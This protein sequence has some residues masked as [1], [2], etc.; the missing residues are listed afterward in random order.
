MEM[1]KAKDMAKIKEA[2]HTFNKEK[3]QNPEKGK[4]KSIINRSPKRKTA[5]RAGTEEETENIVTIDTA[6]HPT[7]HEHLKKS[8]ETNFRTIEQ[9][10]LYYIWT[11][12]NIEEKGKK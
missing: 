9:Q 3:D 12:L 8:A 1:V 10:A 7:I 2:I 4:R 6:K 11:A 5:H